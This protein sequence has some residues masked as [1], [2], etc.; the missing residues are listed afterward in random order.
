MQTTPGCGLQFEVYT[1]FLHNSRLGTLYSRVYG[2]SILITTV[3]PITIMTH[4]IL[5]L[6]QV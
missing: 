2:V 6:F 4:I 5:L 1:F 3:S